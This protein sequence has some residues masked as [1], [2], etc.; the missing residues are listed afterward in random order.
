[1]TSPAEPEPSPLVDQQPD[2]H[3]PGT[4]PA[5]AAEARRWPWRLVGPRT[6]Q[7]TEG[8]APPVV[9]RPTSLLRHSPFA[10]GFFATFGGITAIGLWQALTELKS[11]ILL[12]VVSLFLALGLNPV[13]EWLV[14]KGI[15]RGL[16]V[17]LVTLG[18]LGVLALGS[19]AVFPVVSQQLEQLYSR[20]PA[21]IRQLRENPQVAQL[22][23]QYHFLERI[24]VFLTSGDLLNTVF[25]GLLGAGKYVAS[26]VFSLIVTLVLTI[27]FLAS[28]ENIK[29]VIYRLSPASKRSRTR[30]IADQMF[31]QIGGYL[32]GMFIVVTIAASCAFVFM[33]VVGL[34]EYALALAFVVAVFAF[35]PLVGTPTAMLI[36]ALVGFTISP[37]VSVAAIIYFLIYQQFDAYVIQ[38]RV[39]SKQVNVPG[40][41]VVLSA[42]A[43][44]TLFGIIGA[45]IAIPT[46]AV[47]LLLYREVV[48]PN[49]D[50]R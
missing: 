27:Y 24:T 33:L 18:G 29:N 36:V 11:I 50:A 37:T 43:G 8:E 19:T 7:A 45:L 16:A 26:A 10:L 32:T 1:M 4:H 21:L 14:A 9:V 2:P 38:P 23:Q 46:A 39:M 44:G 12:V 17:A 35:I 48:L 49:L 15:R 13:V 41:A 28:L 5:G 3:P 47:L 30:Y 40:A 34:G 20:G 31:R 6:G 25:G 22:D 42:L